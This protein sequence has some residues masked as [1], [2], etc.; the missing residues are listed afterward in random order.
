[1]KISGENNT[2][3]GSQFKLYNYAN[4]VLDDKEYKLTELQKPDIK[5]ER[6]LNYFR[7]Y[8]C[9]LR[10]YLSDPSGY[11]GLFAFYCKR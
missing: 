2:I 7:L 11:S 4:E 9:S 1:M 3:A 10:R 8:S 6:K 5:T